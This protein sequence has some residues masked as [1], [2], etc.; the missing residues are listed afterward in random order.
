MQ[1]IDP[2]RESA[3]GAEDRGDLA[4]A[5]WARGI[6][7]TTAS[8]GPKPLLPRFAPRRNGSTGRSHPTRR[9]TSCST[10]APPTPPSTPRPGRP[11]ASWLNQVQLFFSAP[12]RRVLRYGDFASRDDL[13]EKLGAYVIRHNE[14]TK[15]YRWTYE[16]TPLKAA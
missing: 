11:H 10:A 2:H 13:I 12:T 1:Q 3:A 15:P 9:P 7:R 6:A 14:T 4:E 16:G 8:P 5:G